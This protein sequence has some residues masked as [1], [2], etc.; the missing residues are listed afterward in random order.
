M[1]YFSS[2]AIEPPQTIDESCGLGAIEPPQTIDESCG[3]GAIEPP[4]AIDESCVLL[5][6]RSYQT[7]SNH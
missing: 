3:L 1:F 5:E 4:Q 6:F 2:G 7:T